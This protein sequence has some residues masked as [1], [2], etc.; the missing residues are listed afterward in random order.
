MVDL[1]FNWVTPSE[2]PKILGVDF[3][4]WFGGKHEAHR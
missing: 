4:G 1:L 3:Q 2:T